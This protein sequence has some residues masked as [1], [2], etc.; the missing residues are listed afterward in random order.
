[1]ICEFRFEGES[2]FGTYRHVVVVHVSGIAHHERDRVDGGDTD[3]SIGAPPF[4][5]RA[6][7]RLGFVQ[8]RLGERELRREV[9]VQCAF[10]F[11]RLVEYAVDRAVAVA[12]WANSVAAAS[13]S[14]ARVVSDRR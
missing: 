9:K 12:W 2:G 14:V 7:D 1:V 5:D 4:P 10:G 11:S 13:I 8:Y 6:V 3:T